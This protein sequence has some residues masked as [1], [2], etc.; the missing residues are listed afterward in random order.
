MTQ[1]N[2][3]TPEE[4]KALRKMHKLTQGDMS[5]IMGLSPKSYKIVQ[6]FEAKKRKIDSMKAWEKLGIWR[7][8]NDPKDTLYPII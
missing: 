5:K 6:L 3:L 2:I 4:L 7:A 8:K 1:V